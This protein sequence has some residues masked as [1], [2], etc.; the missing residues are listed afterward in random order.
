MF[1]L[2]NVC[3]CSVYKSTNTQWVVTAFHWCSMG[4]ESVLAE[5]AKSMILG[6]LVK[7]SVVLVYDGLVVP[8]QVLVLP[9]ATSEF[10]TVIFVRSLVVVPMR[11]VLAV[12]LQYFSSS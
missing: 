6:V 9:I 10:W 7:L 4:V 1:L 5:M 12:S 2:S 8:V 3:V 11:L